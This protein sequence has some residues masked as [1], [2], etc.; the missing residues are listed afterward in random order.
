MSRRGQG[1]AEPMVTS[2]TCLLPWKG[3][4]GGPQAWT[5]SLGKVA[6]A[7][8][9]GHVVPT[10]PGAEAPGW[11]RSLPGQPARKRPVWPQSHP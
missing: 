8:P 9:L 6:K 10:T 2:N 7:H 3:G 1:V 5:L 11:R 4:R